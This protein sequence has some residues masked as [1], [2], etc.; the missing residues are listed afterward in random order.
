MRIFVFSRGY[1]PEFRNEI[2][3]I[4][5]VV[6][7]VKGQILFNDHMQPEVSSVFS[8][9]KN[10]RFLGPDEPLAGCADLVVSLG[11]DGTLLETVN[12]IRDSRIPVMGVNFGRLGFLSNIQ[13]DE[14]RL[15]LEAFHKGS[16]QLSERTVLEI[17]GSESFFGRK[18]YALNE[19]AVH[20]SESSS[21]ISIKTLINGEF[22][23]NYWSDGIILATPT[24]S[25]AYSL[26]CGGPIMVPD[27][28]NLILT[29]ISPHNLSVRPMVISDRVVTT[30]I[31]EGRTESFILAMDSNQALL[32]RGQKVV[33]RKAPFTISFLRRPADSFFSVI[34]E[35]L[36]WGED[37]RN[38]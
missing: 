3:T 35:K 18:V 2:Q 1:S 10:T 37:K 31:P 12:I 32:K 26:S 30:F 16:F 28:E 8:L 25:T 7:R 29:P 36:M 21:M 20:K 34:R 24:G 19:V 6:T 9:P 14:L 13:K 17:D 22:M 5:D 27:A 33:V 4:L 23:N 11:G 38:N 15:T